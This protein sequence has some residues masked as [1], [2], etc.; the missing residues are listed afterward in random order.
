MSPARKRRATSTSNFGVSRRES[1]DSSGFYG[2]FPV[3]VIDDDDAIEHQDLVDT[4][5]AGSAEDMYQVADNSVGLVVTSPPYFAGKAYEED[6]GNGVVPSSYQNYLAM[7]R[8]VFDECKRVLEPGGRIAVNVA[9][10]GR[11]PYRSL[12]ADVIRILQDDL[13]LLL[14]GE[15]IWVKGQGTSGSCA[16]GS[17]QQPGNPVL[18]DRT[19]RIIVASKGRFDRARSKEERAATGLPSS[20]TIF[21]DEFMDFT[22]DVWEFPPESASRI[23]HPAPYPVELPSRLIDLYTYEGDLVLDPFMGSG[24]TAVAAVRSN[25][26]YIGYDTDPAYIE[27]AEER[28]TSAREEI[29]RRNETGILSR[30]VLAVVGAPASEDD[31]EDFQRRAVREGRKAQDFAR[32]L[33][34]HFGFEQIQD[35]VKLACGV[36]VNFTATDQGKSNGRD[37]GIWYFDVSGAFTSSRPGLKRTDTLWKAVGRAA[38]IHEHHQQ[39]GDH[40]QPRLVLLTT[41]LPPRNSTGWRVLQQMTGDGKPIHAVIEMRNPQDQR[42]LESFSRGI[43]K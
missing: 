30:P 27:R 40:R 20:S 5:F 24:T 23:G 43:Q 35:R 32:D 42:R 31:V 10:L 29:E 41:D 18:R 2:R 15:I 21:R 26:R 22:T 11:R 3:P 8:S 13:G 14:R 9:N 19:E 17:F 16:W 38:V 1:H 6:I 33:L 12:S 28:I 4:I 39:I 7:L 34:V 25:R 36:E 37:E